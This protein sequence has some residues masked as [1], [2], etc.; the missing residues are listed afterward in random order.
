M[1]HWGIGGGPVREGLRRSRF[2]PGGHR[3]RGHDSTQAVGVSSG[4]T[5]LCPVSGNQRETLVLP[6][7]VDRDMTLPCKGS[8]GTWLCGAALGD[9]VNPGKTEGSQPCLKCGRGRPKKLR[10]LLWGLKNRHDLPGS[11]G[12]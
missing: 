2:C 9:I 7:G 6:W 5:W 12:I 3:L 1:L 4:R 10:G 11:D 8:Q